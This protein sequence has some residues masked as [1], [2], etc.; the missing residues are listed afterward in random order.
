MSV[1]GQLLGIQMLSKPRSLSPPLSAADDQ[2][3]LLKKRKVAA[4]IAKPA[5]VGEDAKAAEGVGK[6]PKKHR[7]K[8]PSAG[9]QGEFRATSLTAWWNHAACLP[10]YTLQCGSEALLIGT[11]MHTFA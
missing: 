10:P 1:H 8:K 4:S 7:K 9:Q 6:Q 5:P 3:E 2:H 11:H